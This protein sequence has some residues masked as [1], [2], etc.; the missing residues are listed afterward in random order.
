MVAH[1]G[2]EYLHG[3][4]HFAPG[5]NGAHRH[6]GGIHLDSAL[7]VVTHDAIAHRLKSIAKQL[8]PGHRNIG[9]RVLLYTLSAPVLR[10]PLTL[11]D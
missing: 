2:E 9:C 7:R 5:I 10:L 6:P 1:N 3:H 4:G 11:E 8:K